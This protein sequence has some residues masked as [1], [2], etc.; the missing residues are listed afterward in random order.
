MDRI[1]SCRAQNDRMNPAR[2]RGLR[3][4]SDRAE[5]PSIRSM[6]WAWRPWY[7][8]TPYKVGTGT[9]WAASW[10]NRAVSMEKSAWPLRGTRKKPVRIQPVQIG[11]AA[12]G[13][14]AAREG[15]GFMGG[16]FRRMGFIHKPVG[17][18]L[19][20]GIGHPG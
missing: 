10:G 18:F 2:R 8:V 5:G 7:V 16:P 12:P 11:F 19:G 3:M 4:S 9:R 1:F 6:I 13:G 17:G 20:Q 15:S 14:K